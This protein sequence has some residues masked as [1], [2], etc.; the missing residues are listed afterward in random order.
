MALVGAALAAVAGPAWLLAEGD[1]PPA[2]ASA[3]VPPPIAIRAAMPFEAA[4][5]RALFAPRAVPSD[6]G[7]ELGDDIP[8][9]DVE[10]VPEVAGIVGRLPN[11]AV[12]L[13]R[14]PSGG[15]QILRVGESF[16]G[17]RLEALAADAALF[18]RGAERAR[19][20]LPSAS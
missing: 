5:G 2:A 4:S 3:S 17:W 10:G 1:R 20:N 7:S 12:V 19:V 18:V 11:D 16:Q 15:T 14:T 13:V 9:G 8:S 6:S